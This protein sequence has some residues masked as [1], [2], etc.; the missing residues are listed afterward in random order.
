MPSLHKQ[1]QIM[2]RGTYLK[3]L[4]ACDTKEQR[5]IILRSLKKLKLRMKKVK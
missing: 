5:V 1:D 3:C 4:Q 2:T